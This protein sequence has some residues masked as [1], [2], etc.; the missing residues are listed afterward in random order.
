MGQ[1]FLNLVVNAGQA[2][3]GRPDATLAIRTWSEGDE[4]VAEVSDN[5]PGIPQEHLAALFEPFH[6][7][8]GEDGLGLGLWIT[9]N[10]V[11]AQGGR[12]D[13]ESPPGRGATFRVRLP[14][15]GPGPGDPI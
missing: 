11:N 10:I 3:A 9:H 4:Q 1:V 15:G 12:I 14:V 7:T 6:S 8:K 13:V 2:L 5:G